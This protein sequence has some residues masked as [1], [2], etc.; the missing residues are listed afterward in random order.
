[1]VSLALGL[2]AG[3]SERE[4][5]RGLPGCGLTSLAD[6]RPLDLQAFR[7]ESLLLVD[8]WA[9]WCDSCAASFAFLDALDREFRGQGLRVLGVNLDEDPA[10]ARA[11]LASHP[12]GFAQAAD[13]EGACPRRFGVPGMPAT[14]LI[15]RRGVIRHEFIG[16]RADHSERVRR[17]VEELL[18]AEPE[19]GVA[20]EAAAR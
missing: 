17:R 10:D 5:N 12:V 6:D 7:G 8:F 4:L 18:A 20:A 14:Y 11:F 3:A 15:D 19:S 9:S 2:D 13:P 16:F 1:L